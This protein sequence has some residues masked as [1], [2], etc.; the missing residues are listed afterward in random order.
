MSQP[1]LSDKVE[2][3]HRALSQA[4]IPHAFGGALALAYYTEPRATIDIDINV[5]VTPSE[6]GAVQAALAPLGVRITELPTSYTL[7]DLRQ[8]SP[9]ELVDDRY[10][11]F[12]KLGP[13][14]EPVKNGA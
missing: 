3:I 14:T 12:R 7:R 6:G 4:K 11:K 13:I 2:A 9:S 10:E 1:S 8:M 5:F